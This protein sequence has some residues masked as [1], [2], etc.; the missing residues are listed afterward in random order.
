MSLSAAAR[1]AAADKLTP[2]NR[3]KRNRSNGKIKPPYPN[4]QNKKNTQ[5][6]KDPPRKGVRADPL[7]DRLFLSRWAGFRCRAAACFCSMFRPFPFG[8]VDNSEKF[9]NFS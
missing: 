3:P 1:S 7:A 4:G 6:Q 9:F 2:K 8:I 5:R